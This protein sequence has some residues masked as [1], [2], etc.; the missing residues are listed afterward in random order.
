MYLDQRIKSDT[1]YDLNLFDSKD[2]SFCTSWLDTR[3][4]GSVVYVAFGSM[5][6]LNSVQMEEL[7]SAIS[8]FSFLWVVRESEEATMPSGFLETVDKDK[9][10][11]LK[12]SPQLE[13]L[14]NKAIGCFLTHCGWNSTMEALTFGVPMVAMP[15]WTDQP[16]NAKYIQDVWKAGVRV[17]MDE[18]SGIVKREEIDFSIKEV[19]EG[20]KSKEMKENAKKWRDLAVKSL[21]EGGSTDKACPVLTVGPT[22]LVAAPC[23]G[24]YLL[25]FLQRLH[26]IDSINNYE[27]ELLSKVCPILTI[28]PTVPSM[29]LD[30]QI[31]LDNDNDLN[32][33]DSK[34]AALCTA[35]LNTR[36]ERSVVYIAFGSMAQLS[37]VQMEELASAV[38]SFSY[39][40]VVRAS[41]ESKLPSGFLESVD[42]DKCLVLRWSPQLEVLSNKAVGCFMTHCGWNS[43]MEGLTLGV[44]MV[45]MPQWTDQPMNAKYIQDVWKVGVR[46]KAEKETGV[47]MREEIEFSIKEVMEGEKSKEMK[48][49]A[50]KWR[51]LA[52]K[53]LSEGG[54]TDININ[55]FASKI[56]TK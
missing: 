43:T 30:Q 44:P 52:V 53:S 3:P 8:N 29:Y 11:V 37:S 18:E 10:L 4:Q 33:F 24:I 36:P 14:S 25:H 15:Q 5:A 45:A 26:N 38:R 48:K 2:S 9:S 31:K 51:D 34:E 54:S 23:I 7:A 50:M 42:K 55:I 21:S 27:E 17:K 6:K 22:G 32:L 16:M 41:E 19:M 28:G 47:A 13:V 12:W 39:L 56:Q 40:W 49:N 1:D 20:E 35:W 46:V